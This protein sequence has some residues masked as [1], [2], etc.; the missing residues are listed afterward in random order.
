MVLFLYCTSLSGCQE[1]APTVTTGYF[2]DLD[3][4]MIFYHL[5]SYSFLNNFLSIWSCKYSTD[6]LKMMPQRTDRLFLTAPRYV[7]EICRVE[8][9]PA[10]LSLL[11]PISLPAGESAPCEPC[12]AD[13]VRLNTMKFPA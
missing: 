9:S 2:H 1:E 5:Q 10:L 11:S 7:P 6:L 12:N 4:V 3:N 13:S 8:V